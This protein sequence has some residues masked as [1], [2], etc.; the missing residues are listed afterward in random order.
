MAN[1]AE[2]WPCVIRKVLGLHSCRSLMPSLGEALRRAGPQDTLCVWRPSVIAQLPHVL[3]HHVEE[4]S[5][6]A[7]GEDTGHCR[8]KGSIS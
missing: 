1:W 7:L 3:G 8:Q 6:K 2:G 4:E 5:D